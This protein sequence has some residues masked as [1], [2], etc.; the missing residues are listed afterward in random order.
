MKTN[1]RRFALALLAST[2]LAMSA[3]A[4]GLWV[5]GGILSAPNG[6]TGIDI[7]AG[8]AQLVVGT[9]GGGGGVRF[10]NANNL[11]QLGASYE[12]RTGQA[13][14]DFTNALASNAVVWRLTLQGHGEYH[15]TAGVA[16]ASGAGDCGTSP[17]IVGND[18]VGRVTVGSGA[19]GGLCTI[20]FG[21]TWTN[22]P[23]CLVSDETTGVLTRA[24]NVTT[25][26]FRIT[27][28]IIAADSLIYQCTGYR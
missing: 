20:T 8:G 25:A 22:A 4:G 14:F 23:I 1:L 10:G 2:A 19:N 24:T 5:S 3:R 12:I 15:G 9:S 7:S 17:S 16:V 28:V 26:S 13:Q 27:G 11:I 21:T 6:G 18:A